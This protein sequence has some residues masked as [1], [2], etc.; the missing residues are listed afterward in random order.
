MSHVSSIDIIFSDIECLEKAAIELGLKFK[1]DQKTYRW[2]GR[3][4][5]DY[6]AK[7]AAYLQHGIKPEEYGHGLHAIEVP[8]SHYDIGVHQ[9][10]KGK[11][12]V[13][14]FDFYGT[15]HY[16]KEAIGE[17]GGR[18]KQLYAAHVAVKAAKKQGYL[19]QRINKND[20][21]IEIQMTGM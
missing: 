8:N 9:N 4:A 11:G 13:L 7:D 17:T 6:S 1:R 21:T 19:T 10:P 18:L 20:G 12:Y 15:G 5:N 16:I 2:Y 14:T 3:W